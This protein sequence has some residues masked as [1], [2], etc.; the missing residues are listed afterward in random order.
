[1]HGE[2]SIDYI[3]VDSQFMSKVDKSSLE[4]LD[5]H[6]HNLE[7]VILKTSLYNSQVKAGSLR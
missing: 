5:Q 1:M 4:L 7:L 3:L 6:V 2:N